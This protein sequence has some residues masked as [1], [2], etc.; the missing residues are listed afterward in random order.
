[1]RNRVQSA[2]AVRADVKAMLTRW[3][4]NKGVGFAG[5]FAA[6]IREFVNRPAQMGDMRVNQVVSLVG[7]VSVDGDMASAQLDRAMCA[8]FGPAV[9]A[10]LM[11]AVD[12][13]E[14]PAEG[15]PLAERAKEIDRID[16]QIE[17]LQVELDGLAR[18][19]AEAGI[20]L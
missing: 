17:K 4:D 18:Q 13:M 3:V 1:M 9:K 11:A 2:P 16:Q 6:S 10:A 14:W 5:S 19:A 15:L 7:Q 20:N 8:M 12:A